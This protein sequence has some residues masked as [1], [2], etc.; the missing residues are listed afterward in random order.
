MGGNR[1]ERNKN[2]I[3]KGCHELK[4]DD[5]IIYKDEQVK[6]STFKGRFFREQGWYL[7]ESNKDVTKMQQKKN[8]MIW[9]LIGEKVC[10]YYRK[11]QNIDINFVKA[12]PSGLQSDDV[13]KVL[14][15]LLLDRSGSM[16]FED[17]SNKLSRWYNLTQAVMSFT[18]HLEE[19]ILL[20]KNSRITMI[21][22]NE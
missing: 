13:E 8:C 16:T 21:A 5:V 17:P 4:E 15:I 18:T 1:L 7:D 10:E 19:D 11:E 2:A 12:N 22:Y 20:Q 3:I 9:N 6:W 14:Y